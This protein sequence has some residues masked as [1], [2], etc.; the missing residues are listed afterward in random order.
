MKL[1]SIFESISRMF[2]HLE[3]YG[4]GGYNLWKSKQRM[5]QKIV[6]YSL[7]KFNHKIFLRD[8]T[9]D[10]AI[11]RQIFI[12]KQY[13]CDFKGEPKVIIDCGAN[14]GFASIFFAQKYPSA[15]IIAIEPEQSNFKMLQLNTQNFQNIH[16]LNNGLWY[17]KANLEVHEGQESGMWNFVVKEVDYQNENTIQAYSLTDIMEMYKLDHVD[18]L[19]IDIEGSEKEVFEND[20]EWLAKTDLVIIELHDRM[21]NGTAKTFFEA[22]DPFDY[23]LNIKGENIFCELNTAI[24]I[25]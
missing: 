10:Y 17:K 9:S 6:G 23:C 19:K 11:F 24:N 2:F 4:W 1:S 14:I 20:H 3:N 21:R 5:E 8:G 12:E 13:D 15:Q 16:C 18:I 22:I 25:E 7:K